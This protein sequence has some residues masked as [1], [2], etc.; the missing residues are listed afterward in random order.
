MSDV[1]KTLG[2]KG[3]VA[4]TGYVF[5]ERFASEHAEALKRY[6]NAAAKAREALARAIARSSRPAAAIWSGA[7]P[8][9]T[10]RFSLTQAPHLDPW[11]PGFFPCSRSSPCGLSPLISAIPADFRVRRKWRPPLARRR[12]P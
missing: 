1:E 11:R 4:M 10:K 9:S 3:P 12:R 2:A 8:N 6:L 5:S 7:R